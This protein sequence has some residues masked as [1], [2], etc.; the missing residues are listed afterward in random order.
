MSI[1]TPEFLHSAHGS[2]FLTDQDAAARSDSASDADQMG[3]L[4]HEFRDNPFASFLRKIEKLIERDPEQ[5]LN[6]LKTTLN[7]KVFSTKFEQ[8]KLTAKL[9]EAY[10]QSRNFGWTAHNNPA[11]PMVSAAFTRG[12]LALL[13]VAANAPQPAPALGTAPEN[14]AEPKY[15]GPAG[16]AA[17]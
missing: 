17:A 12:A 2:D 9:D 6:L 10:E 5:A 13:P 7:D 14:S 8:D 16:F 4:T 1:I 3:A 11:V 15:N